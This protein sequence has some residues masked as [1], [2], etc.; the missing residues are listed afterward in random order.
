VLQHSDGGLEKLMAGGSRLSEHPWRAF[1]IM[2]AVQG[3]LVYLVG[4][5]LYGIFKLPRD[6]SNTEALPTVVLFTLSGFLAY[7]IA[8][9]LLRLPFGKRTFREY[10]AD[11]RLTLM[12]PFFR[13]LILTISCLLIVM[14]CMGS[15]SIVYRLTQGKP[16]TLEF[17]SGVFNLSLALPPR[18]MLLFAVF[19]SMFEEVAFRGVLLRMLL[20][21]YPIGQAII[22]SAVAFGLVHLPAVFAGSALI[23]TLGQVVWAALFG[24]FYAYLV[25]RTDSLVPAMIIHWLI[26]VFQDPLTASWATA[27][28]GVRTLL[29]IVFGYGL[30]TPLLIIWVRFFA[31]KWLPHQDQRYRAKTLSTPE[32]DAP[33]GP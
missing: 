14:L 31:R 25:V 9:Y 7:V 21:K 26:N 23:P 12:R 8:P 16:L 19:Y 18:S 29:G 2:L 17:V 28:V 20:R 3:T 33:A 1:L 5:I 4:F 10:L 15:G 32:P 24:L 13:S 22:Y 11:I 6:I 30:A 27:P